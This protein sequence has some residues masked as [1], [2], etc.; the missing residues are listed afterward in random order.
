[1]SVDKH[2]TLCGGYTKDRLFDPYYRA[3]DKGVPKLYSRCR[4]DGCSKPMVTCKE[5]SAN[6]GTVMGQAQK[7]HLENY[8]S[9]QIDSKRPQSVAPAKVNVP[10]DEAPPAPPSGSAPMDVEEFD[11]APSNIEEWDEYDNSSR[12]M[13]N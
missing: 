6:P 10:M 13:T 3:D 2:T 8:H 4:I 1:M 9:D 12:H 5:P 11:D 7:R